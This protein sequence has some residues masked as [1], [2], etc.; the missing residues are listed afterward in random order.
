MAIEVSD[1]QWKP[2]DEEILQKRIISAIKAIKEAAGVGLRQ[3][4]DIFHDRYDMLRASRSG[5]FVCGPDEY[6]KEFYS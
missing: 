4:G 2:I 1:E 6:W 5:E 3:A